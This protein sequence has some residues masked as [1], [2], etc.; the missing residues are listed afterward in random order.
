[1]LTPK[2]VPS[3]AQTNTQHAFAEIIESALHSWKAQCW[4]WDAVPHFGQLVT[5][6]TAKRTIFGIVH[7]I[8]TGSSDP[9]RMPFSYQ[10]TEEELLREQ[11]QIFAFLQTTFNCIT[12][13]FEENNRIWYQWV[14]QPPKI[15]AFVSSATTEQYQ[16]FFKS[17]QYLNLLFGLSPIIS[18]PDELILAIL[19]RM[20][21]QALLSPE[22]FA[23][24]IE[25]FSLLTGNEYRRLKL[26]LQRVD[27]L[28][29]FSYQSTLTEQTR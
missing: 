2:T 4:Q 18:Q 6:T 28:V 17:D 26:F 13:G 20:A 10:K 21:E 23:L 27:H 22:R 29:N 14:P 9:H 8:Q 5:I 12:V 1:M 24:F 7:Q 3:P 15:H 16:Q 25:S 11:P 19:N